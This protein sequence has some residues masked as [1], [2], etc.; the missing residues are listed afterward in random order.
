M[1]TSRKSNL[2]TSPAAPM[3]SSEERPVK[4]SRSPENEL[5]WMT[6]VATSPLS[7]FDL[8]HTYGPDG[9]SG[10]TSP[11]SCQLTEDKR[12]E[13]SSK[14]WGKSGMGSLTE[15]LTLNTSEFPNGAVVS[16]LSDILE[17]GAVPQRYFLSRK[18]CA[19]ILRRAEKRGKALPPSLR[20]ALE[21]VAS[22]PTS[23]AT[24]GLSNLEFLLS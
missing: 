21:A 7:S 12:L 4:V 14:R 18:A 15:F 13:P 17:T 11:V 16:S 6:L 2:K 20:A 9:W 23:T 22:E 19:G 3:S 5:D 24:E 8:L 1:A 10:K